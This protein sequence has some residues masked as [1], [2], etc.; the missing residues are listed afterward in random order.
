MQVLVLTKEVGDF[1]VLIVSLGSD[2][3][4]VFCLLSQVL[5]DLRYRK[6]NL[7]QRAVA[8]DDFNLSSVL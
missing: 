6:D 4:S 5:T 7:L 3:H 1:T 2:K 8:A